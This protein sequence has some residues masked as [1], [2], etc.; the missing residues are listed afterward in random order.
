MAIIAIST[1]MDEGRGA[2]AP[3]TPNV[4]VPDSVN[5]LQYNLQIFK[6]G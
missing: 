3:P 5:T 4:G 6:V 1:H 2:A